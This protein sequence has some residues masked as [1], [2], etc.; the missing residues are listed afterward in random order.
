MVVQREVSSVEELDRLYRHAELAGINVILLP[1]GCEESVVNRGYSFRRQNDDM[2]Y[3]ITFNTHEELMAWIAKEEID[4][5][6][7]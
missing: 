3:E 7:S 5:Q 4:S 1:V 2:S 6:S